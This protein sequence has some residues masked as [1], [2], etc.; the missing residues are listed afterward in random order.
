MLKVR[1]TSKAS[2]KSS[3]VRCHIVLIHIIILMC[4][5]GSTVTPIVARQSPLLVND[6]TNW[7]VFSYFQFLY[8]Y[9]QHC[10]LQ[11]LLSN[12]WFDKGHLEMWYRYTN[13]IWPTR[14]VSQISGIPINKNIHFHFHKIC[15]KSSLIYPRNPKCHF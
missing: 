12:I 13:T 15:M 7:I 1:N 9:G 11:A 2:N 6:F 14:I 5:L 8:C 4:V 10:D 3:Q